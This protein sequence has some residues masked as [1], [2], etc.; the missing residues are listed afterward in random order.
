M[1]ILEEIEETLKD[2]KGKWK[3]TP[4][5]ETSET[6][7]IIDELLRE[8]SSDSHQKR[9]ERNYSRPTEKP[10][11][12]SQPQDYNIRSEQE[13]REE[14][15]RSLNGSHSVPD[16]AT[17]IYS[18]N[19][20]PQDDAPGNYND[21]NGA[22]YGG[23]DGND[24]YDDYDD[25]YY[26]DEFDDSHKM[27][28]DEFTQ[29]LDSEDDSNRDYV[30]TVKRSPWKTAW[31]I[32][33]TAVIAAFTIIGIF[34]SVIFCMEKLQMMPSDK[35]AE[36]EALKSEVQKVIYPLVETE[37][38][39]FESFDDIP[40]E[41]MVN[42]AVWE[43]I[44]NGDISVFKNDDSDDYLIPQTQM[45]YI[46]EK[47]FGNESSV[48]NVSAGIND[49]AVV[50]DKDKK[51]YIVPSYYYIYTMY[52]VVTGVSVSGDTYTVSVDCFYDAPAWRSE[53][54]TMP[55]K[56]MVFTLKKTTDY[57]NIISA[58]TVS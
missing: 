3:Y 31:R 8:F 26:D 58:K 34:S 52:P 51:G 12:Q 28:S 45:E 23:D 29:F 10:R 50:Y 36:N 6:D 33:Y 15:N 46:S 57:Y 1:D 19:D 37:I 38:S 17:Q 43:I 54:K 47:L 18:L 53:K 14:Y 16:D 24:D 30:P 48:E 13:E 9:T 40:A 2:K 11:P 35:E 32:I 41:E 21:Y 44:I 49:I 39:D 7:A 55:G 42:V 22:Y 4:M 20:I 27:N 56:K 5:R 25:E